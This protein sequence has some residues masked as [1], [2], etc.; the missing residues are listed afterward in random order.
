MKGAIFISVII[1]IIRLLNTTQGFT[2]LKLIYQCVGQQKMKK[3]QS[4]SAL[5]FKA[6]GQ[7]CCFLLI[8]F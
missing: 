8:R 4:D 2:L 1:I 7:I 6:S 5:L 3:Q